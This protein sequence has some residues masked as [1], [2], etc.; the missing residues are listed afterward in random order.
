MSASSKTKTAPRAPSKALAARK[1]PEV[2]QTI[3]WREWVTLPNLKL[4][5]I[6][7]KVD[8]GARSSC[9]DAVQVEMTGPERNRLVKFVVLHEVDGKTQRLTCESPLIDQR[10]VRS[11]DGRREFRPV[12]RTEVRLFDES[13][14]IEVTLTS[15]A[16]MGFR[17]LLGR[18]AIRK[19]FVVDPARSFV[20]EKAARLKRRKAAIRKA[21][22]L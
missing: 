5:R 2:L 15:R 19:R 8:T 6:K 14:L 17:M 9:L 18:Q 3:G 12:V 7:A 16:V 20:A 4:G 11:S 13:W 1:A 22:V 21:K 10:W